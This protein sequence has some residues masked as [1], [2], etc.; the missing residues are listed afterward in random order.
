MDKTQPILM[1]LAD[2]ARL[3]NRVP[4]FQCFDYTISQKREKRKG[5]AGN[6]NAGLRILRWLWRARQGAALF[7]ARKKRPH[8]PVWEARPER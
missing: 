8:L 4:V 1:G 5:K 7:P 3:E 6:R 2:F